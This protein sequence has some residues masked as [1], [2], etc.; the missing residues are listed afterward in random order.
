MVHA[1]G[2]ASVCDAMWHGK[3]VIAA[4]DTSLMDYIEEGVS[5]YAVAPGDVEGLRARIIDLWNDPDRVEVMGKAA[6]ARVRDNFT[7]DHLAHRIQQLAH[8]LARQMHGRVV[9]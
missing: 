4:N 9:P 1:A 6:H 5:G 2:E 8:L 3:P 7:K